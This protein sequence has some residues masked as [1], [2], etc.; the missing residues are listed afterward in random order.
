MALINKTENA[1]CK[2]IRAAC[3]RSIALTDA[4]SNPLMV[5][6]QKRQ[7]LGEERWA[8]RGA[9]SENSGERG[10]QYL[11]EVNQGS[12]NALGKGLIDTA[13]VL[14]MTAGGAM[15]QLERKC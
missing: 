13:C 1:A 15:K 7:K 8:H 11:L 5:A 9:R 12:S 4:A 10:R 2:E 3:S 14:L 6:G